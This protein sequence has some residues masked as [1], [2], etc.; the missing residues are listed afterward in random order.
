MRRGTG[1]VVLDKRSRTWNFFFW[2]HGRRRSKKIGTKEQ[3]STKT[4]A[5]KAAKSMRDAVEAQ[6]PIAPAQPKPAEPAAPTVEALVMQ[7]RIER[8]PQRTATRRSYSVWLDHILPKWGSGPITDVQPRPVQLWL[9]SMA[10]SPKS[11]TCVRSLLRILWD[12]SMFRGDVPVS[13]NPMELVRIKGATKRVREVRSLSAEQFQKF[14]DQLSDPFRTMALV[15]GLRGLRI[16]EALALKWSD[17]DWLN[18]E[19]RIER[20]I[21]SGRVDDT[22]TEC[23][24]TTVQLSAEV[25]EALKLWKQTTKYSNPEDWMF[26]SEA[27]HGKM[28]W[29]YYTV[30]R[31][32]VEAAKRAEV[33]ALATHTMRHSFR[34]WLDSV[35]AAPTIQQKSMRHSSLAITMKYGDSDKAQVQQAVERVSALALERQ[36]VNGR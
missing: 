25:V 8:M 29:S 2:Q 11:R 4:L 3:Y 17:L 22:K 1:S 30:R 33:G 18:S 21:V 9:E 7:Y 19:L 6:E 27:R 35:G 36:V 31:R 16:S 20:G 24:R 5:W 15:C 14:T 23:S 12:Y 10:L 26:A 28:P 34:S 32:Y 13:R